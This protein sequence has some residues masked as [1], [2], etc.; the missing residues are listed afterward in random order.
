M[1]TNVLEDLKY[2]EDVVVLKKGK[3]IFSDKKEFLNNKVLKEANL[4]G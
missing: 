1:V 3:V 4:Y 2:A